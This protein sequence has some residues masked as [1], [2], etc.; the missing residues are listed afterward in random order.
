VSAALGAGLVP[1][2]VRT[3]VGE[4]GQLAQLGDV[5]WRLLGRVVARYPLDLVG[6]GSRGKP[7]RQPS[8]APDPHAAERSTGRPAARSR[9][10]TLCSSSASRSSVS[11]TV[12][13]TS[14]PLGSERRRERM[15][16]RKR[17]SP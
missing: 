1:P 13:K 7:L 5:A 12:G 6:D 11:S 9:A 14:L 2:D 17:A 8:L 10:V 3:G 16:S 4:A 15:L